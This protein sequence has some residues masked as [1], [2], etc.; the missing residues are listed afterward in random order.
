[1]IAG[2]DSCPFSEVKPSE[3]E[4]GDARSDLAGAVEHPVHAELV[5]QTDKIPA[6]EVPWLKA[7]EWFDNSD[8]IPAY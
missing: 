7:T 5:S 4:T 3:I 2:H 1:M 8:N 6:P